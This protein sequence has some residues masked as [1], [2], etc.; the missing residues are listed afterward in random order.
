[1]EGWRLKST[2]NC[3]WKRGRGR[4]RTE[5]D[6]TKGDQVTAVCHGLS[7]PA[8]RG[9]CCSSAAG[10]AQRCATSSRHRE[11][12]DLAHSGWLRARATGVARGTRLQ[13]GPEMRPR[14]KLARDS[15]RPTRLR[16]L[17]G[18]VDKRFDG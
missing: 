10:V 1:M 15:Q 11:H 6:D 8:L 16:P 5:L 13:C 4:W 18:I 14:A 9:S 7:S 3:R 17:G 12:V 2:T